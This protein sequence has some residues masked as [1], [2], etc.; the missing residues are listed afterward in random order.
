MLYV[1]NNGDARPDVTLRATFGAPRGNGTQAV[2]VTRNGK[3]L[4]S[5]RTSAF[6]K[7]TVARGHGARLYAGMRD[8]PFFFD[9]DGFINI[10]SSKPGESFLGCTGSRTDNSRLERLVDRDRASERAADPQ[11]QLDDRRVGRDQARRPADRPH[12]SPRD[13]DRVHPQNPFE[14]SK[15]YMKDEYN[16]TQPSQDQAKWRS[17]IVDTLTTLYSLNDKS[18]DKS[19][20]AKKSPA[21][22]TCSCRTSSPSTPASPP[23]SWTAGSP[24]TT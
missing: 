7:V 2:K 8:D 6:G 13:R 21:S 5:G 19:D 14:K 12:G 15:P 20:D 24:P 11:G 23:A 17:E 16:R 3:A 9:L 1:D 22:P 4:V 18:D 10:L